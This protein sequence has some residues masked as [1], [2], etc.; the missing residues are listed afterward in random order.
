MDFSA[1]KPKPGPTVDYDAFS[2]PYQPWHAG[3]G[4]REFVIVPGSATNATLTYTVPGDRWCRP[5]FVQVQLVTDATVSNR[6]FFLDLGDGQ[7]N[8][9][10]RAISGQTQAASLTREWLFSTSQE[11]NLTDAVAGNILTPMPI[12]YLTPGGK[13]NCRIGQ[14]G[15]GDVSSLMRVYGTFWRNRP[16]RVAAGHPARL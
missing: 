8:F 16:H 14:G 15:A 10:G 1:L 9:L 3:P 5:E 11:I 7:G 13:I 4:W 12:V 6:V 2:E